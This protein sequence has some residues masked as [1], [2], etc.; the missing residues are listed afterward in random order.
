MIYIT[1][2]FCFIWVIINVGLFKHLLSGVALRQRVF[3]FLQRNV[4]SAESFEFVALADDWGKRK[5]KQ[6]EYSHI[7]Y[8][9]IIRLLVIKNRI[10]FTNRNLYHLLNFVSKLSRKTASIKMKYSFSTNPETAYLKLFYWWV[11]VK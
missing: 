1:I 10:D 4:V 9:R 2:I 8:W 3:I 11:E 5:E 7:L 6:I